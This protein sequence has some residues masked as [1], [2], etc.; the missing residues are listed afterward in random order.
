[1]SLG[2][3]CPKCG[4]GALF[5]GFLKLKP[6]CERC[7]IDYG[8]AD[9]GDGPAVFVILLA[10]ALVVALVLWVEVTW[11]PPIWLHL[12]VFLPLTLVVCLGMLRPLKAA[13][14]HQQFRKRAE[15]GRLK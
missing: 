12:A 9:S 14:I 1:M 5:D 13:L 7:G 8:F 15:Q 3:H 6:R 10:G 4:N 2:N 11:E